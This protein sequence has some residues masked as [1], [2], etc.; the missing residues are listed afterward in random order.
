MDPPPSAAEVTLA[1]LFGCSIGDIRSLGEGDDSG[2]CRDPR[3]SQEWYCLVSGCA[4]SRGKGPAWTSR[5]A[6]RA[7]V[8]LH[9]L[10]ELQ[11]GALVGVGKLDKDG[12][13]IPLDRDARP[14]VMAQ[15]FRKLALGVQIV[16]GADI[17]MLKTPVYGQQEF[18]QEFCD[19]RRSQYEQIFRALESLDC[20]H[21]A[22]HLI[23]SN[24]LSKLSWINHF[25]N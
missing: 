10:G 5:E 25:P 8:D 9:C 15:V 18:M 2:I 3:A 1:G 17:Q 7:P 20:K 4:R 16:A 11:G 14:I 24:R 22:F 6:L 19:V 23:G 13:L 12:H 21:V